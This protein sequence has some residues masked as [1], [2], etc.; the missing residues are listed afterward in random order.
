[1]QSIGERLEEARKRRG[2]SVREA[3]EATKIRGDFLLSFE[4]NQFDVGLPEIYIRGFL[5]NYAGFLKID[6]EKIVTDYNANALGE[7]KNARKDPRE[8]FGRMEIPERQRPASTDGSS[9]GTS[10]AVRRRPEEP[11]EFRDRTRDVGGNPNLGNYIKI[12][13]TIVV[14]ILALLLI[15]WFA[16]YVIGKVGSAGDRAAAESNVPE[17]TF[18]IIAVD[19][20]NV[21]VT[22]AED[23]RVLFYGPLAKGEDKEITRRSAVWVSWDQGQNLQFELENGQRTRPGQPG[24]GRVQITMPE[25]RR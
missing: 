14:G 2:I 3:S 20:V 10:P 13:A 23:G 19:N 11:S 1:M 24:I 12:G 6:G 7:A 18:K 21:Q 4:N 8:L 15:V 22:S 17:S 25:N 9:S 16:T 5:R